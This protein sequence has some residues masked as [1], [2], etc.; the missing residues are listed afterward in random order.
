MKIIAILQSSYIPWKGYFDM[1]AAV[2]KFILYEDMQF[3]KRKTRKT[4]TNLFGPQNKDTHS[5]CA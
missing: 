3:T 5:F 4:G 2:D 1:I